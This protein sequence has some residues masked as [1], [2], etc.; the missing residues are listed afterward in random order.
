MNVPPKWHF[1]SLVAPLP[2]LPSPSLPPSL[3][4]SSPPFPG[5]VNARGA[6]MIAVF[7]LTCLVFI[8]FMFFGW[9]SHLLP[10]LRDKMGK[11]RSKDVCR[12]RAQILV[13]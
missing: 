8:G 13:N 11:V 12:C 5:K 4:S 2:L 1:L 10:Q 7:T 9:F 6:V 3:L